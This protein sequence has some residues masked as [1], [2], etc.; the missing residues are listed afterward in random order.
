MTTSLAVEATHLRK[1][2]GERVAVRDITFSIEAGSC[3]GFLGPNG[4]G[5]STTMRMIYR[6]TPVG[7]GALRVLGLDAASGRYDREI[8]RRIG[9]VHQEDNLDQELNVEETLEV[10]CRFYRL[11]PAATRMRVDEL[12][13]FVNLEERRRSPIM[14]LSGGMK[15]R[16]MVARAL[17]GRPELVVLDEPTTGLD[18]RARA[19][20]WE[21]LAELRRLGTTLL[22]TTHYM[23]EAER[24]C[25]R[26]AMVDDGRIVAAASPRD[27]IAQ[28]PGCSSLEDVFMK[29]TG[30]GLDVD[31]EV[32]P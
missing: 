3:F 6:A 4:A 17:V 7:G 12:L 30:R 31:G 8:K 27:L 26:V 16:L 18:P 22:L 15:R 29:L 10:F 2:Y 9:V 20:L 21:R 23:E 24:L 13:A 11:S 25:D 19:A 1:D 32:E 28:S 5:K 14:T